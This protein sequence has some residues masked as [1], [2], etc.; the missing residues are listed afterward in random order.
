MQLTV[1]D[2]ATALKVTEKTVYRWIPV[3]GVAGLPCG[4]ELPH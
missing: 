1:K 3:W 2:A 4:G